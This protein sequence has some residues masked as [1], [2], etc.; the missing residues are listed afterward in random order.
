[1]GFNNCFIRES[2]CILHCIYDICT[3]DAAVCHTCTLWLNTFVTIDPSRFFSYT[4]P[5][6]FVQSHP[7]VLQ[8]LRML[9]QKKVKIKMRYSRC[10]L[11]SSTL[12]P[13]PSTTS[14]FSTQPQK[15]HLQH[16]LVILY[17]FSPKDYEYS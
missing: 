10:I 12:R 15:P 13:I 14:S 16:Q 7:V 8:Y 11:P 5:Q 3:T 4:L 6:P 2:A 17:C 1:M 9:A